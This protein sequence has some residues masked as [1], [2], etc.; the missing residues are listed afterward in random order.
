MNGIAAKMPRTA[1]IKTMV[2]ATS[3]MLPSVQAK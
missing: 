3:L 2:T 1:A